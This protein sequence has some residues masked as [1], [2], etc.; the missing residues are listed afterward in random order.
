MNKKIKTNDPKSSEI[1]LA[2]YFWSRSV[3]G[4]GATTRSL[5]S[6]TSSIILD[7]IAAMMPPRNCATM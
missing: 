1:A 7:N 2:R 5:S 3:S 4:T 6:Y